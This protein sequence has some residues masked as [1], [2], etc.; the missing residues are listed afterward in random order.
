M[1][2]FS[3]HHKTA[4]APQE[5]IPKNGDLIS[6]KFSDGSWYRARVNRASPLKKEA[7][8]TFID[9]GNQEVVEFRNMRPLDPKFRA[10]P[11]QAHDAR[12]RYIYSHFSRIW[13]ILNILQLR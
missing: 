12:L 2:E 8:I 13:G 3:L 4:K 10:L 1:R 11:G 5:F 7:E 6:A 9:Y